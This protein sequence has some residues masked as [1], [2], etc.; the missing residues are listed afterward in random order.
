MFY[1]DLPLDKS[2]FGRAL[3]EGLSSAG[4]GCCAVSLEQPPILAATVGSS[5]NLS[6]HLHLGHEEVKRINLYWYSLGLN[7][8]SKKY[9]FPPISRPANDNS[10]RLS[11]PNHNTDMSLSVSNLMLSYTDTYMC[12]VSLVMNSNSSKA[13]GRG[14]FLLVYEPMKTYLSGGDIVCRTKVQSA[15]NLSVVWELEDGMLWNGDPGW[16]ANTDSSF[17]ISNVFP[18]ATS[19]CPEPRNVTVTC[20]LQYM[21]RT[22]ARQRMEMTCSGDT[23]GT[24][25]TG[26]RDPHHPVLLYSLI[27]GGTSLILIALLAVW[28]RNKWIYWMNTDTSEYTNISEL[29]R[30]HCL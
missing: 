2:S 19:V 30:A 25:Q 21:G 22:V 4:F 17:W 8:T 16:L 10:I 9:L 7:G 20:L 5:V 11:N 1:V 27:L 29:R 28:L 23:Y 6:C 3:T 18:N 15:A 24:N 26:L 12:D 14:T 13:T